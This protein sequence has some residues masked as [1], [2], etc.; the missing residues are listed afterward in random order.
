MG[1]TV[2]AA[3]IVMGGRLFIRPRTALDYFAQEP[4]DQDPEGRILNSVPG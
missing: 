3:R 4:S 2:Y 1:E